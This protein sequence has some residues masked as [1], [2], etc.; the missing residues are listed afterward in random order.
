MLRTAIFGICAFVATAGGASAQ[1][2]QAK[3]PTWCTGID[4]AQVAALLGG[5]VPTPTQ[6]G[7][8]KD[9]DGINTTCVFVQGDR[10][11]VAVRIEFP[12]V[13]EAEK[14]VSVDYL[15]RQHKGETAKYA[16]EIG[17]GDRAFW[18]LAGEDAYYV[19]LKGAT[20]YLVGFGGGDA[21]PA[22]EKA[23][24]IKLATSLSLM[25]R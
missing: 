22:A 21:K 6:S 12:S 19:I 9:P 16:E 7:P 13:A 4:K 25:P 15:T 1:A 14:R 24:L 5:T 8:A 20:L 11:L 18:G 17:P 23:A 10:G 3:P 2:R